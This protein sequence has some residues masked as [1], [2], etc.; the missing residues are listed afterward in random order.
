MGR[1]DEGAQVSTM[2]QNRTRDLVII[3]PQRAAFR[4]VEAI[5][6]ESDFEVYLDRRR[7]DRRRSEEPE[8]AI[9]ERRRNN[10][11]RT[12][13]VSAPLRTAGW[14]LIPAQQRVR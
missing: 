10:D 2:T 11:R 4:E 9:P 7:N 5:I 1:A 13:D 12:L 3:A 8:I 14:V 6:G